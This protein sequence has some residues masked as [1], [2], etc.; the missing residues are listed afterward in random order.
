MDSKGV[1]LIAAERTRHV[2]VEGFHKHHDAA[3]IDNELTKAAVC[4]ASVPVVRAEEGEAVD[5]N[6]VPEGLWPWEAQWW[7]P[8]TDLQCLV[9]AGALI[10]AE[11][12]RRLE[13]DES[14]VAA[15]T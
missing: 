15:S 12:D 7:K 3:Y 9:K 4:Y 10:A 6:E 13:A 11:I 5:L 14:A 2:E 8:G 1:A